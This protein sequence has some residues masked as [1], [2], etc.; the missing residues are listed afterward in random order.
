MAAAIASVLA[1]DYPRILDV[2]VAA[3]D[4][5]TTA[6]VSAVDDE[7]VRVIANPAG[8]TPRALNLAL[9]ATAGEVVVRCDA[10]AVLPPGYVSRAV[11][12]LAATGAVNVG[13]RQVPQSDNVF[14]RAVAMAMVSPLG[15]GDAR[16][17]IGGDPGPVDTVYLGVFRRAA[18][19]EVGGFDESMIRNQDYAMNWRLRHA[20]GTVWFDPELAVVYEPRSTL[21]ALWRQYFGYGQGKRHMLKRHPGSLKARQLA[22]PL[23]V[24]GIAASGALAVFGHRWALAA[25][26]AYGALTLASGVF[27]SIR[28]RTVSGLLEPPALWTMHIAWGVGFLLG[29]NTER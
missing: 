24:V 20:G 16:Y 6:A 22:A 9:A 7:R 2:V 27:D 11:A 3:A 28:H 15:A 8:L 19:T 5:P 29:P 23:L 4:Q 1:Q 25:P 18:L 17:R 10:H 21:A 26:A 13:G 12:T 14:G